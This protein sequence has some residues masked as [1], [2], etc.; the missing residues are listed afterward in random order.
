M[1]KKYIYP[2]NRN[3]AMKEKRPKKKKKGT[4]DFHIS[5]KETQYKELAWNTDILDS[6]SL[7]SAGPYGET[8]HLKA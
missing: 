5:V 7:P 2:K 3:N 4:S 1:L 8:L 6:P